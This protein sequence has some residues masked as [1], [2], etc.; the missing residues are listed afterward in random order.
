[1]E[2]WINTVSDNGVVVTEQGSASPNTFW[3]DV[4][5]EIVSGNLKVAS[6]PHTIG[7]GV[8][9]G[10]VARNTWQQY[11]MVYSAGTC[12]GYING[13]TTN[14]YSV[15]RNFGASALYYG[16]MLGTPTNLGDGSYLTGK[17]SIFR[18][19]NRAL[20]AAEVLQN[21]QADSGRYGS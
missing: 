21:Y 6:W 15:T 3:Y 17:W 20:S 1:L 11:T 7:G 16:I 14:S 13:A 19:Y 18:V 8:V 4:N 5:I 2:C 12:T 10:A 9:V